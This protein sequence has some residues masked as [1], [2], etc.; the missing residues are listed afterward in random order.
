MSARIPADNMFTPP[1]T[2]KL[3]PAALKLARDFA[4]TTKDMGNNLVP[5]F[6]WAMSITYKLAPD[7]P[8]QEAGDCV[9]LGALE[10]HKIPHGFIQSVDGV[11]F[12]IEIPP[13]IWQKCPERLIDVDETAFSKLTLR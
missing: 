11:E 4:T 6:D 5:V 12:A 7:A 13:Q 8:P 2:I 9:M 1:G 3:S 10:R